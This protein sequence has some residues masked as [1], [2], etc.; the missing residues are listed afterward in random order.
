M[1]SP[2]AGLEVGSGARDGA[3]AGTEA[4][5]ARASPDPGWHAATTSETH[6]NIDCAKIKELTL[7]VINIKPRRL[8]AIHVPVTA[9]LMEGCDNLRSCSAE[10]GSGGWEAGLEVRTGSVPGNPEE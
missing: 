6:I 4:K 1:D 8:V 7:F 9:W 10:N 3:G 5:R 2:G